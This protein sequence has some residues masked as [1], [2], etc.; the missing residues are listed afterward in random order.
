M[1]KF[2]CTFFVLIALLCVAKPMS[3]QEN[4]ILQLPIPGIFEYGGNT[5]EGF[6]LK[7]KLS[8]NIGD[9]YDGQTAY[10]MANSALSSCIGILSLKSCEVT[11][12]DDEYLY[13]Y[14]IISCAPFSGT[15]TIKNLT[16][17]LE[18]VVLNKGCY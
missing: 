2:T 3:S 7:W 16:P 10:E 12:G 13:G 1:K 5:M 17:P 15:I 18:T 6:A 11:R 9:T 8:R 14:V 4:L